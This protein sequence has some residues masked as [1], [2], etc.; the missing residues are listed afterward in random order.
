M[1]F[2]S[3]IEGSSQSRRRPSRRWNWLI[4]RV[5]RRSSE[6]AVFHFIGQTI[7]RKNRYQVYLAM[8]CGSGLALAIACAVLDAIGRPVAELP[9]T[10]ERV[11]AALEA[12]QDA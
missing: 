4:H 9:L 10:P 2:R 11:L 3:A 12:A 5:V 6:R 7:G 1:L 8:Y